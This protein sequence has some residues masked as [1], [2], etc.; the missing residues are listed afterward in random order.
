MDDLREHRCDVDGQQSE[1]KAKSKSS[2][3]YFLS[4]CNE[5]AVNEELTMDVAIYLSCDTL[6]YS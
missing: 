5:S 3:P 2:L 1:A 4:R 6:S